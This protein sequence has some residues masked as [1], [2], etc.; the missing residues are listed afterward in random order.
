M[1]GYDEELPAG[2]QDADIEQAAFEAE[3]ARYAALERKGICTHS[4]RVGLGS[5]GKAHY[6]EAEGL[7][8]EQVRCLGCGQV[9]ESSAD[10]PSF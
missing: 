1:F 6:P 5:D 3:S 7:A 9:F 2:F 10:I 4:S 8:G